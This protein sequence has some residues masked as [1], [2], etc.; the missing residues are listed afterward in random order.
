MR[1]DCKHP[2]QGP[3]R[4]WKLNMFNSQSV[5]K[6]PNTLG[7]QGWNCVIAIQLS[8]LVYELPLTYQL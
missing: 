8:F 4:R 6:L 1:P 2:M 7:D 3:F 5:I